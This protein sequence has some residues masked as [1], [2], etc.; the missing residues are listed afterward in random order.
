MSI[1]NIEEQVKNLLRFEK[2]DDSKWQIITEACFANG[3]KIQV[4]LQQNEEKWFLSD[5]KETL[6]YMNEIYD[7]KSNDVKKCIVGVLKVYGFLINSGEMLAEITDEK[8]FAQTF[9]DFIM[10]IGQL[11]NMFVFFDKP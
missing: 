6:K 5:N 1:K 10:C 7:L 11:S 9:F 2:I 4:F 3:N 8:L